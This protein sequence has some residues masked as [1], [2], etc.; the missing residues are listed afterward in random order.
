MVEIGRTG[1]RR[2]FDE[3]VS[4]FII[5]EDVTSC[6]S[7]R[8]GESAGCTGSSQVEKFGTE[9]DEASVEDMLEKI[10]SGRLGNNR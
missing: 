5:C 2:V 4:I 10:V 1:M 9:L 8:S 6:E 7:A 3:G